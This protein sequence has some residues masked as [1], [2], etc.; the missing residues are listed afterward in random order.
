[1]N[2]RRNEKKRRNIYRNYEDKF[3]TIKEKDEKPQMERVKMGEK[4]SEEKAHA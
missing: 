1:M 4:K 3:T 2:S